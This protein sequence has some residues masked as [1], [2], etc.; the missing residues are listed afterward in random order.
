MSLAARL[1]RVAENAT[2]STHRMML[3]VMLA[4]VPGG[5]TSVYFFGIGILANLG[6]AIITAILLEA[7]ILKLRQ[8]SFSK[9]LDL[10]AIVTA[11]LLALALPPTLPLWMVATGIAFAI[12][13]GKHIYGGLGQNTF[14]PAMV[15]YAMLIISFPLAMSTWPRP[16]IAASGLLEVLDGVTAATPLDVMKFRGALTVNEVWQPDKGF[17]R[18]AGIGWQWINLAYLLGGL[19]LVY[20]RVARWQAAAA[21]LAT[22]AILATLYY[23]DGGGASLGSPLFHLFSGG[24]ML[25]AF[26]IVTDPVTSPDSPPGL[27]I[28]GAGVGLLIFIIRTFGAY[29]DGAA[30]AILM[31]NALVPLIETVR[32]KFRAG[33]S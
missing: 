29:P 23:D 20:F 25:V 33:E 30:F 4:L 32:L 7:S 13:F 12:I 26:F 16:P 31:M 27:L 9:L 22:L 3:W 14:N 18:W 5:A 1:T 24:T 28:F 8:Q 17:D 15:G 19:M 6:V 10:S 21:M 11:A 2:A